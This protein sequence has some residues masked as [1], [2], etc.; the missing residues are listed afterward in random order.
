MSA[1]PINLLSFF[2]ER[3]T[4]ISY[5]IAVFVMAVSLNARKFLE[6]QLNAQGTMSFAR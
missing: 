6:L 5:F 2:R 1:D 3:P 4:P